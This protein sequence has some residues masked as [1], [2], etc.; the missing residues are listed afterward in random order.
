[1]RRAPLAAVALLTALALAGCAA[2]EGSPDPTPTASPTTSPSSTTATTTTT[3]ASTTTSATPRPSQTFDVS[4]QGNAFVDG[5]K[6]IQKGD[7]VR[8]T[9]KDST[10]HT[11]TSDDGTS[12]DSGNMIAVGPTSTFSHKFDVVGDF[13]YHCEVHPS[14]KATITVVAALPA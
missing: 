14:M 2:E 9:Q 10:A 5:T 12:F 1:M 11:V 7:T 3:S 4:I 6:T 8:W 13:P